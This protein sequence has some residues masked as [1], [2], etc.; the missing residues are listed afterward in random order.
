M[1]LSPKVWIQFWFDRIMQEH[2]HGLFGKLQ[3]QK[4]F[5]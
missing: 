3:L 1:G 2:A 4:K 5:L